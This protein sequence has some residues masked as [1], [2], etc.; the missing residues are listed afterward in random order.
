MS[1]LGRWL[2]AQIDGELAGIERDRV[3][4][5][6]AGCEACREEANTLRALKR[7]MTELGG[8]A[9][10]ESIAG[11]LI[12]LG[13]S[14]QDFAAQVFGDPQF[15]QPQLGRSGW[16]P[17]F[18]EVDSWPKHSRLGWRLATGSA[19]TVLLTLGVLA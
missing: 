4:N 9:D 13:R 8:S 17:Q 14:D 7:R 12:E 19:G 6:I 2:S 16:Q 1:H 11:R 10:E 3:L 15:G 18:A 5:H